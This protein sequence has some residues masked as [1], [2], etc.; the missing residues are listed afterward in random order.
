MD[1]KR[2]LADA[3]AIATFLESAAR[4][5]M[6]HGDAES[7]AQALLPSV[8]GLLAAAFAAAQS[9][10]RPV[11][12]AAAPAAPAA[13]PA[14]PP[15]PAPQPPATV[16]VSKDA[17]PSVV[18]SG[19][20]VGLPGGTEVFG[21]DNLVSILRG[22]NRIDHIGE[23]TKQFMDL[24]LV[25]LVKDPETGRG[26]FLPVTQEEQVLRLAGVAAH[27]DAADYGIPANLER[28]FDIT[29]QLVIAAALEALRDAGIPLQRTYKLSASGKRVPQGW[30]LPESLRGRD[31]R[32]LRLGVPRL[33]PAREEAQHER[34]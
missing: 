8:Q 23:R 34:R 15:T 2:A 20:S 30:A 31:R 29:T 27:F 10:I 12:A 14:E 32:D 7:F 18:C 4:S 6:A 21:R 25:R 17:W 26:S 33:R 9:S 3:D 11:P 13:P 1:C 5:G 16:V 24:D 22:D 19:A 28:A